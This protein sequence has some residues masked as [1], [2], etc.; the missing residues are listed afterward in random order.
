MNLKYIMEIYAQIQERSTE[1][2]NTGPKPGTPIR[3]EEEG[4]CQGWRP[5][6][7]NVA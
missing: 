1:L 5:E 4:C 6:C 3:E 2:R 7:K